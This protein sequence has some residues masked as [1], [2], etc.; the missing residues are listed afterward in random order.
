MDIIQEAKKLRH[1]YS[2]QYAIFRYVDRN[3]WANKLSAQFSEF[4]IDNITDFNYGTCFSS[5]FYISPIRAKFTSKEYN[6]YLEMHKVVY[7][8][9][10]EVSVIA[11]YACIRYSKRT[12]DSTRSS[13]YEE[14]SSSYTPFCKE[15]EE[16]GKRV[17]LYLEQEGQTVLDESVLTQVVEGIKLELR[18]S[19][20][21]VYNCLFEDEYL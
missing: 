10:V 20:V 2:F 6:E 1:N 13:S 8:I 19:N 3:L 16:I 4:Y 15:H 5:C 12:L 18:E 21:Q 11:P 14:V 7:S 17:L 9:L